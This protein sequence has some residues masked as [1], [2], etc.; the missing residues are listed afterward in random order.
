MSIDPLWQAGGYPPPRH[1][2][3]QLTVPCSHASGKDIEVVVDRRKH[4]GNVFERM[5][6]AFRRVFVSKDRLKRSSG[7]LGP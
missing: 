1:T 3:S 2:L 4:D 6:N 5:C 7:P